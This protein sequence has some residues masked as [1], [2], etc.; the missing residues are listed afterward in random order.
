M[1]RREFDRLGHDGVDTT[2]HADLGVT[3]RAEVCNIH[4]HMQNDVAWSSEVDVAILHPCPAPK[5]LPSS[6][7]QEFFEQILSQLKQAD[8]D[9]DVAIRK[10]A[11]LLSSVLKAIVV[12]NGLEASASPLED[13][14]ALRDAFLLQ[15]EVFWQI[16]PFTADKWRQVETYSITGYTGSTADASAWIGAVRVLLVRES[17]F[18]ELSDEQNLG[19]E[20]AGAEVPCAPVKKASD[21]VLLLNTCDGKDAFHKAPDTDTPM[22]PQAFVEVALDA[23]TLQCL[24]DYGYVVHGRDEASN[25]GKGGQGS[26]Y[27]ASK[28]GKEYAIKIAK[29]KSADLKLLRWSKKYLERETQLHC[30]LTRY[31]HPNLVG[32]VQ[33]IHNLL[34]TDD[35]CTDYIIDADFIARSMH[36]LSCLEVGRQFHADSTT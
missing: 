25:L 6:K 32:F 17:R 3:R 19:L 4:E 28:D 1:P 22:T 23:S 31:P 18:A 14:V 20:R 34:A 30:F 10:S 13:L 8:K 26:V 24:R 27:K 21:E 11:Q 16:Q 15:P 5:K 12:T 7:V 35:S 9:P 29:P 36:F 2:S 33:V